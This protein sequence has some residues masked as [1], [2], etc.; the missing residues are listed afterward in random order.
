MPELRERLAQLQGMGINVGSMSTYLSPAGRRLAAQEL[1][2]MAFADVKARIASVA[3]AFGQPVSAWRVAHMNTMPNNP[4]NGG[5]RMYAA[6]PMMD[7]AVRGKAAEAVAQPELVQG[8]E[9]MSV[10]FYIALRAK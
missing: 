7:M 2:D 4:C 5:G 8:R 10:N 9:L 3:K 1:D 6:A